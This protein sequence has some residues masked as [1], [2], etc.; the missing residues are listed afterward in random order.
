MQT[1]ASS[2]PTD[3]R[4]G[5]RLR[6]W[7]LH[8]KGWKQQQIAEALGLTQGAVSQII[9][10]AR[11]GGREALQQRKAPGSKPRLT[12]EQIAQLLAILLEGA[13]AAGFAGAVWTS[14]RIAQVIER[15]FGVLYHP[16]YIGTL[17]KANGWSYQS[18]SAGL[19][20]AM[21]KPLPSGSKNAFL[22]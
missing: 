15:E 2:Q 20:N 17:L 1:T 10:R 7:E 8:Q 18:R 4:E 5:R 11:Q 12:Q 14:R 6:V 16:D 3:W 13:Q 22:P 19:A 9:K 21:S